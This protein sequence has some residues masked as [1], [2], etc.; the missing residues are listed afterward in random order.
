MSRLPVSWAVLAI[1]FLSTFPALARDPVTIKSAL[2]NSK[3]ERLIVTPLNLGFGR[4]AVGRRQIRTVTLT[5]SGD[6]DVRLLQVITRGRDF[7]V[8]GLDL[9]VTLARGE[10]YTFS[11]VFAPRSRGASNGSVAFVSDASSISSPALSM[12]LTGIGSENDGQLI[13]NPAIMNFGTVQVG[14]SASQSGTL[15]AGASQ[16]IVSSASSSS[17][18]FTFSGLSFPVIIPAGGNQGFTVTFTPQA[19]G[20]ASATLSFLDDSGMSLAVEFLNGT[21]IVSQNHSVGLS[22]VASTSQN[23]IGYNIYRGNQSGGP[24]SKIN[25]SLDSNTTYTDASVAD[26]NTY[27][28]VTT[29]VNSDNEESAYSNQAQATIP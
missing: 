4:V 9:P 5:N 2:S 3:K 15:S 19:S 13:I 21:G 26:G 11:G 8:I 28:Y 22:W 29:A 20:T 23:V 16:I 12:E 6:S 27:Y 18:E 25:S 24:Y 17:T 7:A 14:L 1:V 10:S